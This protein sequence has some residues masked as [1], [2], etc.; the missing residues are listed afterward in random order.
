ML[1]ASHTM[2]AR[3]ADR[4][5]G[6]SSDADALHPGGG[7]RGEN[8]AV[9]ISPE[10]PPNAVRDRRTRDPRGDLHAQAPGDLRG[11]DRAE[12]G[13]QIMTDQAG[14]LGRIGPHPHHR[15]QCPSRP[16]ERRRTREMTEPRDPFP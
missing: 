7:I 2:P 14:G 11:R 10:Q 5:R 6:Q 13:I 15:D 3:N 4:H 8:A 9:E 1:M 16:T 12:I